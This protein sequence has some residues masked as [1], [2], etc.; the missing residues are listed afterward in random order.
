MRVINYFKKHRQVSVALFFFGF[1]FLL[2]LVCTTSSPLYQVNEWVDSNA[3]FTM[4]K[5]LMNGKVLYRDLFD[6]K[7]PF[8]YL[9]YG[10]GYLFSHNSF[11]GVFVMESLALGVTLYFVYKIAKLFLLGR[12][13]A[14]SAVLFGL[15]FVAG[16]HFSQGGSA[17]EFMAPFLTM[18]LYFAIV[19]LND[20]ADRPQKAPLFALGFCTAAIFLIKMNIIMA[21]FPIMLVIFVRCLLNKNLRIFFINALFYV[22]G[23]CVLFVPFFLYFLATGSLKDFL[24]A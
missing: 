10:I 17:E 14:L 4:G 7:G 3:Y 5:G 2:L 22:A 8:L 19:I 1:S 24:Y 23:L 15:L 13:A 16:R 18:A 21:L 6:H 11:F 12:P 9:I 20:G